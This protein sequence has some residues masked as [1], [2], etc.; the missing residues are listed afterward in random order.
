MFDISLFGCWYTVAWVVAK[1]QWRMM[2][3]IMEMCVTGVH[4]TLNKESIEELIVPKDHGS[5]SYLAAF[6]LSSLYHTVS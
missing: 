6:P 5:W 4:Q 2:T 3:T 1:H